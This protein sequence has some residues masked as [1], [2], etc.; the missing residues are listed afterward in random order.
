MYVNSRGSNEK[1]DRVAVKK[2]K[3]DLN[4]LANM[5]LAD[6]HV[7]Q[8]AAVKDFNVRALAVTDGLAVVIK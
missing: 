6:K 7:H 8:L 1:T 5:A 4:A 2:L 3:T